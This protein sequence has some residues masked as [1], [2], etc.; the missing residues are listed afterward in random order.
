[1]VA[2]TLPSVDFEVLVVDN[3][4]DHAAVEVFRSNFALADNVRWL[5]SSPPGLSRARN[6]AL[7]MA[8]APIVAFLDDDA[9]PVSAW[10]EELLLAFRAFPEAAVVAGPIEPRW[11]KPRPHWMPTK[12]EAALGILDLGPNDRALGDHES[13]FGANL[14][15]RREAALA[16]GAFDVAIG[17]IG[18][19]SLLSYEER[20]GRESSTACR[21]S[22]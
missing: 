4:S 21:Q 6:L 5:E 14:A 20:L 13:G 22:A 19:S 8:R 12:Y 9:T 10:A 1:L 11:D 3:S 15:V 18:G 2:Q 17:R 16:V 7:E